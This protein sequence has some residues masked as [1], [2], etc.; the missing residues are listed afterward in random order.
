M[1]EV[2]LFRDREENLK[3]AADLS[4][5]IRVPVGLPVLETAAFIERCEA[6][7]FSGVGIHD[8]QHSGRDVY[9]TLG[10]AAARTSH[11]TLYPATSNPVTRHPAVLASLAHTLEEIAPS[12]VLLTLA[13][14]FL[15]VRNIGHRRARIDEMRDA[16]VVI[17]RLLAGEEVTFA[18]Q[19]TRLLNVSERPTPVYLLAAGPRMVE[20]AGEVAD[21]AFLMTGLDPRAIE[22]AHRHLD[23][24]ARRA[25]RDLTGFGIVHIVTMA[26]ESDG[27]DPLRWPQS[28]LAP[29][30]PWIAYPSRSNLYWLREAGLDLADDV[31]PEEIDDQQA[32]RICDAFGLF[33]TAEHCADRI[34]RAVAESDL[35]RVFIFPAHTQAGGYEM[36]GREIEA[37]RRVIF[38]ALQA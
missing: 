10:L 9:L 3:G 19:T 17:R 30:H 18:G 7:G 2:V 25:G 33:G 28:W 20:L 23:A 13:P 26:L 14:G 15:A 16:V 4:V 24:G 11:L 38:P 31:Q 5:D 32:A 36:P 22:A 34:R 1:R 8:H 12:R 6:A 29:G 37:F 27:F 21:G 35:K